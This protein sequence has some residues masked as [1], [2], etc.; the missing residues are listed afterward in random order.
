M[1][2]TCSSL[3]V[4]GLRGRLAGPF[5]L[6]MAG[7]ECVALSGPSGV[8]KSLLLRMIADLEPAQGRVELDGVDRNRMPAPAF[9]RQV[10]Y[11]AADAGW[12]TDIV[13]DHMAYPERARA[14]LPDLGLADALFDAPV[15]TLSTGQR[16]RF[17]L[18]R[19]ISQRPR[20]LLLDEPTSALDPEA[21]TRV[22]ALLARLRED[23]AGL[24]VVTHDAAQAARIATRRLRMTPGGLEDETP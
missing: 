15:A 3:T 1:T 23:G 6:G 10:T 2:D 5:D 22:E 9:R 20:F 16:Q 19:A 8:G 14:L 21:I 4:T 18:V 13:A 12:W 17:A 24:L 11:V 7:G